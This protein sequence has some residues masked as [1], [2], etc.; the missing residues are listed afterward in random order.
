MICGEETIH[1]L[2]KQCPSAAKFLDTPTA[3]AYQ[4]TYGQ[5]TIK[6][7]SYSGKRRHVTVVECRL[8]NSWTK[9]DCLISDAEIW[10]KDGVGL[11]HVVMLHLHCAT[12]STPRCVQYGTS[13]IW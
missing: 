7:P 5:Q 6:S 13:G 2:C 1:S 9:V 12:Y 11:Q 3:Y 8:Q 4:T 10:R